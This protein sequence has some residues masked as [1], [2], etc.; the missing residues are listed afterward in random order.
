MESRTWQLLACTSFTPSRSCRKSCSTCTAGECARNPGQPA[1]SE[2]NPPHK[3]FHEAFFSHPCTA[4]TIA[5]S[6]WQHMD[7]TATRSANKIIRPEIFK[8]LPVLLVMRFC[9]S[10]ENKK[11]RRKAGKAPSPPTA[12][13]L[14][15]KPSVKQPS[16]ASLRG[17]S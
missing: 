9:H 13:T 8:P 5:K 6:P 10:H 16:P 12:W 2:T 7:F 14:T 1:P 15:V 11:G 4:G 17:P 3:P